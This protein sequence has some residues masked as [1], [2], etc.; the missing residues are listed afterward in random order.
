M[1]DAHTDPWRMF[2]EKVEDAPTTYNKI[3]LTVFGA[4]GCISVQATKEHPDVEGVVDLLLETLTD[5][6]PLREIDG[7]RVI[8]SD[9]KTKQRTPTF[10]ID[11]HKH[12]IVLPGVEDRVR[13]FDRLYTLVRRINILNPGVM[14]NV[15]ISLEA[16]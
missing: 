2:D 12:S 14:E 1:S 7:F 5:H 13:G 4:I 9:A 6:C 11:G 3:Q 15:G 16:Q 10:R 8:L